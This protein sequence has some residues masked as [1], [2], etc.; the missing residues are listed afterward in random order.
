[1]NILGGIYN[2]IKGCFFIVEEWG[3]FVY[4]NVADCVNK[5]QEPPVEKAKR[6]VDLALKDKKLGQSMF[7]DE[8]DKT[9]IAEEKKCNSCC[10]RQGKKIAIL[11]DPAGI[12]HGAIVKTIE[13]EYCGTYVQ[14]DLLKDNVWNRAKISPGDII[15]IRTIGHLYTVE[16]DIKRLQ[17]QAKAA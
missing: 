12:E 17:K 5:G 9:I 15:G 2:N 14:V 4:E 3:N 7:F 16:A 10:F 1:M 8:F 11:K 6:L 13:A